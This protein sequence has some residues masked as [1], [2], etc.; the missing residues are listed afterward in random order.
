MAVPNRFLGN[1]SGENKA[2]RTILEYLRNSI[3]TG[4]EIDLAD[5]KAKIDES[6]IS[7]GE[8]EEIRKEALRGARKYG[9]QACEN[10]DS[11]SKIKAAGKYAAIATYAGNRSG[12][13]H[14]PNS[15]SLELGD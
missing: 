14:E 4:A 2:A 13:K 10:P 6:E 11:I 3:E 12:Y 1:D 7:P 8:M 5:I 9:E 15:K